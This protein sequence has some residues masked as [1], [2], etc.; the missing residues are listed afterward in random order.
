MSQLQERHQQLLKKEPVY[1]SSADFLIGLVKRA[2]AAGSNIQYSLPGLG[3]LS[4]FPSQREYFSAV[5]DMQAFCSAAASRFTVTPLR[6]EERAPRHEAGSPRNISE[7]LWHAAFHASQGRLVESHYNG[8]PVRIFDVIRFQHWPNLTRLPMTPNTMRICALLTRQPSSILLVSRK[9]GIEQEEV[10]Q[11]YS[12]ACS[13][14]IVRIASADHASVE[15]DCDAPAAPAYE[16]GL[17]HSL[18]SKIAGL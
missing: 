4:V 3:H 8:D 17:L 14:G 1:F 5:P 16:P 13:S 12:A 10:F 11:V 6:S 9:L 2:M 15:V 7:L 18:F